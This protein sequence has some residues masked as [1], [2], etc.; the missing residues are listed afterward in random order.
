ML[1]GFT[2]GI[3]MSYMVQKWLAKTGDYKFYDRACKIILLVGILGNLALGILV[4]LNINNL[5][6]VIFC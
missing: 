6:A 3:L 5:T 2:F 1:S 4:L